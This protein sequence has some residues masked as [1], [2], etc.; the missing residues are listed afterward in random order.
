VRRGTALRQGADGSEHWV[1]FL[2]CQV[3]GQGWGAVRADGDT[4]RAGHGKAIRAKSGRVRY[5]KAP[6]GK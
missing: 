3:Q 5:T 6:V 2:S 1:A 4:K